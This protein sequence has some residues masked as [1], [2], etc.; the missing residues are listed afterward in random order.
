M[1]EPAVKIH[2]VI[3][4]V[5]HAD[6]SDRRPAYRRKPECMVVCKKIGGHK[7]YPASLVDVLAQKA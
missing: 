5:S 3:H 1:M 6:C 7:P 4:M 2:L